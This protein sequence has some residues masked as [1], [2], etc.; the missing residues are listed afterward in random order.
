MKERFEYKNEQ[1]LYTCFLY[2]YKPKEI[3]ELLNIPL[4]IVEEAYKNWLKLKK[5]VEK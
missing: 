3:A 2:G 4:N 5:E 1:K